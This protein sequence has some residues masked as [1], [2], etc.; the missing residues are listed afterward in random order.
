MRPRRCHAL[1]L[2]GSLLL[3]APA[4]RADEGQAI[5]QEGEYGGVKPGVTPRG[6]KGRK[7]AAGTLGWIGFSPK[8]GGAEVFFQSGGPFEVTQR[9]DGSTLVVQ[10]TGLG[11]L[12]RGVRRPV[13]TRFFDSPLAR[14][15][16][17]VVRAQ[18]ARKGRP[19]HAGGVEV[20]IQFKNGKDTRE[21]TVRTAT[22]ADGL[23]YVYLSFPPGTPVT[24]RGG[25]D[26]APDVE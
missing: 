3:A 22:E 10:L 23:F 25:V 11:K 6:D 7:V 14:I 26:A 2:L 8:D 4:A 12:V 19:G 9:L 18:K 1:V 16:A 17:R 5:R 24:E 21:G 20:R 15:A 13:D